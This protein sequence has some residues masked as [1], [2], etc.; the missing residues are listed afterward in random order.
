MTPTFRPTFRF[1]LIQN[2]IS[3][4]RT[5]LSV[6]PI[7]ESGKRKVR[8]SVGVGEKT[9]PHT[10]TQQPAAGPRVMRPFARLQEHEAG[11]E[12]GRAAGHRGQAG[13]SRHGAAGAARRHRVKA[14]T[15]GGGSA[16]QAACGCRRGPG[17]GRIFRLPILSFRCGTRPAG[18]PGPESVGCKAAPAESV[19]TAG[20]VHFR[21]LE[22]N[23]LRLGVGQ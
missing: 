19:T 1:P 13:R 21:I 10:P 12:H 3:G 22:P 14:A 17:R 7:R 11:Y 16:G 2:G 4:N 5:K 15:M 8:F 20:T 23:P 18:V 6:R 9:L